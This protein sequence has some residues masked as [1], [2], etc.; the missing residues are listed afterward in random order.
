MLCPTREVLWIHLSIPATLT[1]Q[2]TDGIDQELYWQWFRR[3]Y[4]LTI[5]RQIQPSQNWLGLPWNQWKI[6]Q[7]AIGELISEPSSKL[8]RSPFLVKYGSLCILNSILRAQN[9]SPP[10]IDNIW[11]LKQFSGAIKIYFYMELD[12]WQEQRLFLSFLFFF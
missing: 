9:T 1:S 11:S 2:G 7:I 4:I 3:K 6:W 8:P 12:R 10:T 5:L